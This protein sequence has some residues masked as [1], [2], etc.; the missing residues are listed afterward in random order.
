MSITYYIDKFVLKGIIIL[1]EYD[2]IVYRKKL[3]EIITI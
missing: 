2:M 1:L 3:H